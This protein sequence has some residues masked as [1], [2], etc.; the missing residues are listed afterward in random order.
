MQELARLVLVE[1]EASHGQVLGRDE[2]AVGTQS[3]NEWVASAEQ[4]KHSSSL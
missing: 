2:G 3:G 4:T 1:L